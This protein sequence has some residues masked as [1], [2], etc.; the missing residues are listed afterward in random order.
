MKR[1]DNIQDPRKLFADKLIK[2]GI[3]AQ[4]ALWIAL[5]VGMDAVDEEYLMRWGIKGKQLKNVERLITDFY[6]GRLM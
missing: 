2:A 5:D 6:L 3:D 1:Y 4:K